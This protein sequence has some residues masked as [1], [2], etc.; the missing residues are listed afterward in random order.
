[1]VFSTAVFLFRFLPVVLLGYL[2]VCASARLL[3]RSPWPA[4]NLWLLLASLFFYAWGEQE[5]V[6]LMLVSIAGNYCFGL[7]A[8][9]RRE[10]GGTRTVV[11]LA[12]VFNL[13]LLG[14]FKYANFF[15]ANVESLTGSEL[16]WTQ[17][18]LPIGISFFTFQ[19]LSYVL[20]V[21]RGQA[22][23][24]RN[25]L[26][27][28][29]YVAL[30]PQL[31]AGPIVRYKDVAAQLVE[32]RVDVALFTSGARRFAIGLA[33]KVLIANSVAG[34]A[35]LAFD[36]VPGAELTP[37]MAWA[38]ALAYTIQI[39][40]DFSGYSDMA[41]GL[42]RMFGFRFFENFRWPYASTSVT[43][44]WRRWHISLSSWFR[45]YLYI[46]LG[47]NRHGAARTGVHLL[48]VFFLCG[49]WHGASWSFV[50]WGLF[51]GAF[52]VIERVGLGTWLGRRPRALRHGY[53]ML[54]AIVGW[55]FFRA[56]SL[57]RALEHL[58]A[59]F[60]LSE[61]APALWP[62]ALYL[63]RPIALALLL[64]SVGSL[65]WAPAL[66]RRLAALGR[67]EQVGPRVAHATLELGAGLLLVLAL[68]ASAARLAADTYNPFIYF[69]F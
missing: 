47:G 32:R 56:E 24:Q 10:T 48:T 58:G 60:F 29:T 46:P 65:P 31:V 12:L 39:Y 35:D 33:K 15:V 27:F 67:S 13:G 43:E 40:F 18:V 45:D 14:W 55:V 25:P 59:M 36:T 7:W 1:M 23:V 50:V 62:L 38:G 51:H 57:P 64:G 54:V 41:I 63:E 44:F 28:A 34:L 20:D 8:H 19:A 16:A 68:L 9:A 26:H 66:G 17:V 6:A 22:P 61:G 2:L 69:R 21:A 11:A 52:L 49:L 53:T 5:R 3:R 4:A 42:G 37:A 30:F